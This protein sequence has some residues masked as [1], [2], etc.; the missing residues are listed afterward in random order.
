MEFTQCSFIEGV[1]YG[2]SMKTTVP[3]VSPTG[4][5][6]TFVIEMGHHETILSKRYAIDGI[7]GFQEI[8]KFNTN[9]NYV[10]TVCGLVASGCGSS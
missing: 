3:D 6:N 5:S 8:H 7:L 9:T 4:S 10:V 2:F 1:T